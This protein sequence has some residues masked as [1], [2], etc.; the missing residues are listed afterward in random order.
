[1]NGVPTAH[2]E[3][4][5]AIFALEEGG[6]PAI[7]ARI[8]EWL[9]VSRASVSEMVHKLQAEGLVE[10]AVG[11][12]GLS[13]RGRQIAE[14][15]VRRHR[16]A[17][18]FLAEVLR[19]PWVKIHAEA[20]VWEHIISDDVEAAMWKVMDDPQTCPHGN[21]I[22]GTGYRAP[23]TIPIW[24]MEVGERRRLE[25]IGEELESDDEMLVFLDESG[26]RPGAVVEAVGRTPHDVITVRAAGGEPVGLGPF[27]AARLFVE[28]EAR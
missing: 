17:E 18:R 1:M 3:Y 10:D 14:S 15:V 12:V 2:R 19:V 13:R 16:L 21:P 25:R 28:A 5:Q 11:A 22:P 23:A 7:Q 20:A 6:T 24:D 4:L 26:L 8:A 27:A 9:G